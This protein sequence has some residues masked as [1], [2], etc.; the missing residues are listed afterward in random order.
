MKKV[1]SLDT[2]FLVPAGQAADLRP[3]LWIK[4]I[5]L[6]LRLNRM[7]E[8]LY[9]DWPILRWI[10]TGN[11]PKIMDDRY[12]RYQM[13]RVCAG[14]KIWKKDISGVIMCSLYQHNG[15]IFSSTTRERERW[16]DN[17][18]YMQDERDEHTHLSVSSNLSKQGDIGVT[19]KGVEIIAQASWGTSAI[20]F[21]LGGKYAL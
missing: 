16:K 12:N 4:K 2:L 3:V 19:H 6:I 1:R 8:I 9:W 11:N 15:V 7:T 20:I 18:S 5:V 14:E 10:K 17:I 21:K 13:E